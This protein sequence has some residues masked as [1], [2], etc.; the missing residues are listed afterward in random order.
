MKYFSLFFSKFFFQVQFWQTAKDTE[1]Y[2]KLNPKYSFRGVF[3]ARENSP[4]LQLSFEFV[5]NNKVRKIF[6]L[7]FW[8]LPTYFSSLFFF[9]IL[10]PFAIYICGFKSDLRGGYTTQNSRW[11]RWIWFFGEARADVFCRLTKKKSLLFFG[12]YLNIRR[13]PEKILLIF[14]SQALW[15][16]VNKAG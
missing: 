7:L 12:D 4:V 14:K 9:F 2:A 11:M 8:F 10:P 15:H 3:Y 16:T 1:P 5:R 6:F 13:R